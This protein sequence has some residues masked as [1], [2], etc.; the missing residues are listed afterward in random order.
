MCRPRNLA[1]VFETK[2]LGNGRWDNVNYHLSQNINYT[3]V[4]FN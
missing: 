3:I 4:I 1:F 2:K